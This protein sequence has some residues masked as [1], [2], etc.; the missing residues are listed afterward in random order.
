MRVFNN[1]G[2]A[3]MGAAMVAVAA[4][5]SDFIEQ[6]DSDPNAIG[7]P[8]P[9]QLLV[10]TEVNTFFTATSDAAR[11]AAVFTQQMSGVDPRFGSVEEQDLGEEDTDGL[12][13]NIYPNAGL[14]N[15]REGIERSKEENK[16]VT[17]GIFQVHEAYMVG[18]A[19]ALFGDIP[20]SEAVDPNITTPKLDPQEEVYA[21]L[22]AVLDSAIAN[23]N[24]GVGAPP[25]AVDFSFAGRAQQWVRTAWSLKARYYLHWADAPNGG[26]AATACGGNCLEKALAAA[27]NGIQTGSP[28]DASSANDNNF[29][30]YFGTAS[31]E[32]NPFYQ[33]EI[34]RP[35]YWTSGFTLVNLLNNGTD[36]TSADDDPRT[37]R[38]FDAASGSFSGRFIGSSPGSGPGDPDKEASDINL[39]AEPAYDVALVSCSETNFIE[40]EAYARLG[41]T[42]NARESLKDA[43]GCEEVYWKL[44]A[45]SLLNYTAGGTR[46]TLSA[47]IDAATGTTI[48][49]PLLDLILTQKYIALFLNPEVYTDVRRTCT[50]DL[51]ASP[52]GAPLIGRYT[53]PAGERQTNPNIPNPDVA[54]ARNANIPSTCT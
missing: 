4:G 46:P 9:E 20:Y 7:D 1:A 10:G 29:R 14:V 19:A 32:N 45:N 47:R 37:V 12:W 43:L 25:P 39:L 16:L 49:S 15:I 52:T 18:L 13:G 22:Q 11:Y 50:P 24:S 35:D 23:L 27:L 31:T 51:L 54:P 36:N 42:A 6:P 30:A 2:R 21:A 3:L 34:Q 53:Y 38:Y 8:T 17:A 26:E 5:C 33:F 48:G 41:Q 40:A 44:P 28:Y